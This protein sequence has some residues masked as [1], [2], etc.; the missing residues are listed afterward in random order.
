[1][2]KLNLTHCRDFLGLGCVYKK[3]KAHAYY[4]FNADS[5]SM[6]SYSVLLG[7]AVLYVY[8]RNITKKLQYINL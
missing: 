8:S 1:M 5:V 3:Y 7:M 4:Y 2:V 6:L